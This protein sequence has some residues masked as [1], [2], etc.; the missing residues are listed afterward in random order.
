MQ[1]T[2]ERTGEAEPPLALGPAV[3]YEG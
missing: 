1:D 2:V 3:W